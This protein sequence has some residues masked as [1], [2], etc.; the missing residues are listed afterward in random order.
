[1]GAGPVSFASVL[2]AAAGTNQVSVIDVRST[3]P[4]PYD[5]SSAFVDFPATNAPMSIH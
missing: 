1:M 2:Q 5:C 4:A 3:T